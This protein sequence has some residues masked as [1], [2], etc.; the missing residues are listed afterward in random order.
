MEKK[1]RNYYFTQKGP[2]V[3]VS[4]VSNNH[5]QLPLDKQIVPSPRRT[6]SPPSRL[7]ETIYLIISVTLKAVFAEWSIRL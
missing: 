1:V 7:T 5:K 6:V 4:D 3:I 2:E